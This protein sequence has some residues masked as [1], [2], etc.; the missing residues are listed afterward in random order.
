M[1]GLLAWLSRHRTGA[2]AVIAAFA[3]WRFARFAVGSAWLVAGWDDI[4]GVGDW[5]LERWP[6]AAACLV[7]VFGAVFFTVRALI[8]WLERRERRNRTASG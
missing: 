7:L 5:A 2:A 4:V 8:P 3:V 1:R 6:L